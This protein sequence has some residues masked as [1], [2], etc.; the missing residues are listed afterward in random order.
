MVIVAVMVIMV[1]MVIIVV[2]VGMRIFAVIVSIVIM[3]VVVIHGGY[4]GHGCAGIVSIVI[5]RVL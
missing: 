2:L 1:S 3:A 5:M 4:D